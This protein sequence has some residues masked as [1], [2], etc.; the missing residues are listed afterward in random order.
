MTAVFNPMVAVLFVFGFNINCVT[1]FRNKAIVITI[2][3]FNFT[4]HIVNN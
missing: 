2:V 1:V 4:E 3:F